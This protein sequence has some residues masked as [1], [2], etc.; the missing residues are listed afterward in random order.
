MQMIPS[1]MY[2]SQLI[3]TRETSADFTSPRALIRQALNE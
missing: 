2:Y 3:L 1:G